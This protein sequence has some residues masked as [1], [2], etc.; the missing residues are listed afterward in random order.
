MLHVIKVV[1]VTST[2]RIW[3]LS[4]DHFNVGGIHNQVCTDYATRKITCTRGLKYWDER[5]SQ[6]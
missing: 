5:K 1:H 3:S 6:I 2:K 4:H